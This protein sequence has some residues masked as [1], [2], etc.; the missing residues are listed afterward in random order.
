MWL[1]CAQGIQLLAVRC[2]QHKVCRS[3]CTY[4]TTGRLLKRL[5]TDKVV[6][7][8]EAQGALHAVGIE[9]AGPYLWLNRIIGI[10]CRFIFQKN[11]R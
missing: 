7:F 11:L 8:G 2:L 10:F 5:F 9:Q 6:V 4:D 3:I 1:L